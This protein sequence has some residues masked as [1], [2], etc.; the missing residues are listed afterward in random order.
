LPCAGILKF[1]LAPVLQ[2][3]CK[4]GNTGDS[5]S[6]RTSAEPQEPGRKP[7]HGREAKNQPGAILVNKVGHRYRAIFCAC[8]AGCSD[9]FL[10]FSWKGHRRGIVNPSANTVII[11]GSTLS[12]QAVPRCVVPVVVDCT[13]HL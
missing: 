4:S 6:K 9:G 7:K 11:N 5:D 10:D 13:R 3:Q 1:L 8:S 2:Q 12:R